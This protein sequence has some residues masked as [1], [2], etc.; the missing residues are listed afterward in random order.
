MVTFFTPVRISVTS[1]F[2]MNGFRG[3]R[4]ETSVSNW[5]SSMSSGVKLMRRMISASFASAWATRINSD[6]CRS[7]R[8]R[9]TNTANEVV[10]TI[11]NTSRA[12]SSSTSEKP[13]CRRMR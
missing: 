1:I 10:M 5:S 13:F 11:V 12:K 7:R 9:S 6:A 2:V 4:I 8:V 3:S